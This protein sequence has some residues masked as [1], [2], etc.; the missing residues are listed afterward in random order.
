[1]KSTYTFLAFQM[2]SGSGTLLIFSIL[3]E[4]PFSHDWTSVSLT[5]CVALFYLTLFGSLIAFSAYN[6]L[7]RHVQVHLVSSYALVTPIFAVLLGSLMLGETLAP[8]LIT[9]SALVIGGLG[10]LVLPEPS[11][12][13]VLIKE[14]R[15]QF[16]RYASSIAV[17]SLT[18]ATQKR[19]PALVLTH[20]PIYLRPSRD[21]S[22]H[23]DLL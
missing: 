15:D 19:Q 13:V 17:D 16:L 1:M 11:S 12:A 7:S 4:K 6:W 8:Q 3:F 21:K 23:R 9:A 20:A 22:V 5:S 18:T 10:L 14:G 2:L